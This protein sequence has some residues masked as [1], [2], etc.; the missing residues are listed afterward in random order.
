MTYW[1]P[2]PHFPALP[3]L[4][5]IYGVMLKNENTRTLYMETSA[6]SAGNCMMQPG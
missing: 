6:G 1:G 2:S 5:S 4:T 3:A